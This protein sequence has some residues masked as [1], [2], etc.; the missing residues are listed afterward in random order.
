MALNPYFIQGNYSEQR[1]LQ[2]LINEQLKMYGVNIGYL[3]RGYAINDGILRENILARFND[4]YYM[5][6]YIASYGGFG[7]GGDL[8]TKFGVQANDDLSLII[9]KE[10][11]EDFITPFLEAELADD[12]LKITNRPK[13]GDLIYFPLTDTLYEIKFVEHEVEFYQLNN[14]YVYELRCEPFVFED[15]VIDTGVFEIDTTVA[16]RG[17]DSILT[18]TGIANTAGAGTTIIPAGAVSQVHLVNDGYGYTSTPMVTFSAAPSG[19]L[20]ATAVAITTSR[21]SVGF[22]SALSIERI[23][24][25]N[26]GGGY[27]AAPTVTISGGGGSGGIATA[28]IADGT[29]SNIQINNAGANYSGA[30]TITIDP[31]LSGSGVTATAEVRIANGFV[32]SIY[33]TNAGAGYTTAPNISILPPGISTGNYLYNEVITGETSGTQAIVKDWDAVNKVLK[34]Y[35]LS[36]LQQRI[37][38][39]LDQLEDTYYTL[40]I[41]I[42]TRKMPRRMNLLKQKQTEY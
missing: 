9:S 20:T 10:K 17:V 1:L 5:E 8:L 34:I 27:T 24:L 12:N 40:P 22:T 25:T 41:I 37:I 32:S 31:P 39:E 42:M 33:I 6:A 11:Y 38:Q 26:P 4:N 18:L 36:G 14:L 7:G 30:P 19:G 2:D 23:V 35:R 28:S 15:E 3:P 21:S 29:I 16:E 13:E